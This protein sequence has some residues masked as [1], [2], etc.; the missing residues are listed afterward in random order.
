MNN[1]TC[2]SPNAIRAQL[3][4]QR[5]GAIACSSAAVAE[6]ALCSDGAQLPAKTHERLGNI[7]G[8]FA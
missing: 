2:F 8:P 1:P 7:S 5:H 4:W 3:S 6:R